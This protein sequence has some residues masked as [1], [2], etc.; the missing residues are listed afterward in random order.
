MDNGQKWSKK[1]YARVGFECE[2]CGQKRHIANKA[3]DK[4]EGK[5]VCVRCHPDTAQAMRERVCRGDWARSDAGWWASSAAE[6]AT[7]AYAQDANAIEDEEDHDDIEPD[8]EPEDDEPEED[9]TL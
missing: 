3:P 5:T 4:W 2:A 6:R 1:S 7:V 9:E 8:D